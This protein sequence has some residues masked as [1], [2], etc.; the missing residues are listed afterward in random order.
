LVWANYSGWGLNFAP[1][2]AT[3]VSQ[4]CNWVTPFQK[5]PGDAIDLR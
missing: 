5:Q 4:A 3:D 1:G 2:F